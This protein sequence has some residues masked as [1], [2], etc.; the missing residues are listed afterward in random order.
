MSDLYKD[1]RDVLYH[2]TGENDNWLGAATHDLDTDTLAVS[3]GEGSDWTNANLPW[4]QV[5]Q[6]RD[7]LSAWLDDEVVATVGSGI[8]YD[9]DSQCSNC[10]GWCIRQRAKYCEDC[11]ARL[12]RGK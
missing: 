2:Y 6:L 4:D 3:I 9:G 5:V 10:K 7:A 12:D 1:G 11:G 8:D